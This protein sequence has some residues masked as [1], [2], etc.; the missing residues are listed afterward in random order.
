MTA[1]RLSLPVAALVLAGVCAGC[2]DNLRQEYETI[3]IGQPAS[4][5]RL[6][7]GKP[8]HESADEW[9]WVRDCPFRKAIVKFENGRVSGMSWS[10]EKT[11]GDQP[12]RQRKKQNPPVG[13]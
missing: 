1:G 6:M 3:H 13:E 8:T 10:N 9:S 2:R 4:D 12:P 7:M 5:V 11:P